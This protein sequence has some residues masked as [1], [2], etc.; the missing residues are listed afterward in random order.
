MYLVY[1][2]SIF[3]ILDLRYLY[4]SCI[5]SFRI[6]LCLY[7]DALHGNQLSVVG[8]C[9]FLWYKKVY[10]PTYVVLKVYTLLMRDVLPSRANNSANDQDAI[11][12]FLKWS[13]QITVEFVTKKPSFLCW[14]LIRLHH[15]FL[16]DLWETQK[17]IARRRTVWTIEGIWSPKSSTLY[18]FTTRGSR[19]GVLAS[20]RIYHP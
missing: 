11:Q 6:F 14:R 5:I 17:V 13:E 10:L 1:N 15:R 7:K 3:I 18:F 20:V 8:A 12:E 2:N 9:V 19:K 4:E 16:H